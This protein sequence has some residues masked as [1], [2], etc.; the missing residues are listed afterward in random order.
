VHKRI[1][2]SSEKKESTAERA[3]QAKLN[4]RKADRII[5]IQSSIEMPIIETESLDFFPH[6]VLTRESCFSVFLEL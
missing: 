1:K 3:V 5:E 4:A 2:Q 6:K